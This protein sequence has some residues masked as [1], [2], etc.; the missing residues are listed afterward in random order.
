[1]S[2]ITVQAAQVTALHTIFSNIHMQAL[3]VR[4][5]SSATASS[6]AAGR[7]AEVEQLLNAQKLAETIFT[8]DKHKYLIEP[9]S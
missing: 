4:I 2:K 5:H 1:M 6:E 3:V 9:K 7:E 8:S